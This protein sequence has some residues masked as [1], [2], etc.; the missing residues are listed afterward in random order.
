[1]VLL[2]RRIPFVHAMGVMF[3]GRRIKAP[4]AAAMGIVNAVVA[5]D[6][7]DAE[8]DAWAADIVACAPLSLRAIKQTVRQSAH[9]SPQNA[10]ALR[11]PAVIAAL[12]SEDGDEGVNA[13]LEKRAPIW[14]GR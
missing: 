10:Q 11:L 13:F 5:P 2:Q 9:L 14:K 8:V 7:L 6:A 12:V 3:T 4:E 1:M